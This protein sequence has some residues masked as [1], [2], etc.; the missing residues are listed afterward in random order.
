MTDEP[1]VEVER[2]LRTIGIT[3][4]EEAEGEALGVLDARTSA[5]SITI[6]RTERPLG[7]LG[8]TGVRSIA[9]LSLP[10]HPSETPARGPGGPLGT[11]LTHRV[12]A[13]DDEPEERRD[14]DAT[15]LPFISSIIDTAGRSLDAAQDAAPAAERIEST[16]QR[17][18]SE[19]RPAPEGTPDT[20]VPTSDGRRDDERTP[21]AGEASAG[22][23]ESRPGATDDGN[24]VPS[25]TDATPARDEPPKTSDPRTDDGGDGNAVPSSADGTE[26]AGSSGGHADSEPTDSSA[27][28]MP[29]SDEPPETSD[30]RTDDGGDGNAVPPSA[31]A[32]STSDGDADGTR[33]AGRTDATPT[34]DSSE[35]AAVPSD[36]DG[37]REPES[38]ADTADEPATTGPPSERDDTPSAGAAT[39]SEGTDAEDAGDTPRTTDEGDARSGTGLETDESETDTPTA[40]RAGDAAGVPEANGPT[41]TGETPAAETDESADGTSE[42]AVD[43]D[44]GT[45]TNAEGQADVGRSPEPE[46]ATDATTA[47][48]ERPP[49]T[50]T[51]ADSS[52]RRARTDTTADGRTDTTADGRTDTT[53]DGRADTTA[54]GRA[55]E[56]T[57]P[58]VGTGR[59]ND[60]R[61]RGSDTES[62]SAISSAAVA[63][64]RRPRGRRTI[65][66]E[67][68]FERH[69]PL[70]IAASG[71]TD[72]LETL[73]HAATAADER[74]ASG[75][76][77]S[78]RTGGAGRHVARGGYESHLSRALERANEPGP[79]GA[80]A[81]RTT[82]ARP[83]RTGATL[84]YLRSTVGSRT[85]AQADEGHRSGRRRAKHDGYPTERPSDRSH[86]SSDAAGRT[87]RVPPETAGGASS[88]G[89]ADDRRVESPRVDTASGLDAGGERPSSAVTGARTATPIDQPD[90]RVAPHT[91]PT[92]V[93]GRRPLAATPDERVSRPGSSARRL[94]RAAPPV[95]DARASG[96]RGRQPAPSRASDATAWVGAG[97]ATTGAR[98]DAETGRASASRP[99]PPRRSTARRTALSYLT[100]VGSTGGDGR[101]SGLETATAASARLESPHTGSSGPA[102]LEVL[103]PTGERARASDGVTADAGRTVGAAGPVTA[104]V[105]PEDGPADASTTRTD[106]RAAVRSERTTADAAASD[107]TRVSG[108]ES[109][110]LERAGRAPTARRV[111]PS[112]LVHTHEPA[113]GGG[114]RARVSA[115][116]Q[117]AAVERADASGTTGTGVRTA[118]PATPAATS[119]STAG[120]VSRAATAV[121]LPK[122]VVHRSAKAAS[123]SWQAPES[124]PSRA[125]EGPRETVST[126]A[127]GRPSGRTP[128]SVGADESAASPSTGGRT[129]RPAGV[130]ASL[131]YLTLVTGQSPAR[132]VD[133]VTAGDGRPV[134][135]A[136]GVH[137]WGPRT[138]LVSQG[139]QHSPD[140]E[141]TA[142]GRG[143]RAQSAVPS[144]EGVSSVP[145][146]PGPS[147]RVVRRATA[148]EGASGE[149]P[150]DEWTPDGWWT[151]GGGRTAGD[152]WETGAPAGGRTAGD[153]RETGAPAGG[154]TAG[155]ERETGA[156]AGGGRVGGEWG[157]GEAAGGSRSGP[158]SVIEPWTVPS[159]LGVGTSGAPSP[160][161]VPSLVVDRIESAPTGRAGEYSNAAG[162]TDTTWRRQLMQST[163]GLERER[164]ETARGRR[165]SLV[166]VTDDRNEPTR[167]DRTPHSPANGPAGSPSLVVRTAAGSR[168][169][170]DTPSEPAWQTSDGRPI[171]HESA[172]GTANEPRPDTSRFAGGRVPVNDAGGGSRADRERWERTAP[173]RERP[174]ASGD[175]Q[176]SVPEQPP[177]EYGESRVWTPH[178]A[179][180]H[181]PVGSLRRTV[182]PDLE[183]VLASD[184]ATDGVVGR[185][186]RELERKV[187]IERTRR[188]L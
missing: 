184:A 84:S 108:E 178:D 183:E 173:A 21:T 143:G 138:N 62:E 51:T 104:S 171:E 72:D 172:V 1:D 157:D 39:G 175:E 117:R 97:E 95:S 130:A 9:T 57:A 3:Q 41:R 122:L 88:G 74:S 167:R 37:S 10:R 94:E 131:S 149:R 68:V 186:Y 132:D 67:S 19:P 113:A 40:E 34:G 139:D 13:D 50:R 158:V 129:R 103:A 102:R 181:T 170:E 18:R 85:R 69:A 114:E 23:D 65:T 162:G 133:E 25:S 82:A 124:G 118:R 2:R 109:T 77:S 28:A 169:T 126:A 61:P 187:R 11:A 90:H 60:R 92:R 177:Q 141:P 5:R 154:R 59:T 127:G 168:E 16:A 151:A 52:E 24:A 111:R 76:R 163:P 153:E 30:P 26:T 140:L 123:P 112:T 38:E 166:G 182:E 125:L 4:R 180:Q 29:A 137:E 188:G 58:S 165:S 98:T 99:R 64:G 120:V 79:G 44:A 83:G 75:R 135:H 70:R 27:D 107:G 22:T 33:P 115:G 71:R 6:S 12:P 147:R 32:T 73:G 161:S 55:S 160:G 42:P 14:P 53:A 15:D 78:E 150:G 56:P 146:V 134:A 36:T 81:G 17:E 46:A 91:P 86:D 89:R 45:A 119:A 66:V 100:L 148:S 7:V 48:G 174:S 116:A 63:A 128:T 144:P 47:S 159:G 96:E 106:E 8:T 176:R 80:S 145:S 49:E 179:G 31:D 155:D 164:G 20:A 156:P 152:E 101:A 43:G 93:V 110:A 142:G 121:T 136:S 105:G 54:D 87:R 185:L 35:G